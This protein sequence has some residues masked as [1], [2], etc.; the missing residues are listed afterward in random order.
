MSSIVWKPY[1]K[2]QHP[3][4]RGELAYVG[5]INIGCVLEN[6]IASLE[7]SFRVTKRL[8]DIELPSLYASSMELGKQMIE[9]LYVEWVRR[10][11]IGE[12]DRPIQLT[13]GPEKRTT[14][15]YDPNARKPDLVPPPQPTPQRR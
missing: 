13:E 4:N 1:K 14:K 6:P 9:D 15:P 3:N 7:E 11:K 2:R 10:T 12:A 8:P 5:I